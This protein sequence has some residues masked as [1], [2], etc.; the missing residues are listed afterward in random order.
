[1]YAGV[2][3]HVWRSHVT[4]MQESVT[5]MQD[6]RHTYGRVISQDEGVM[7]HM[8]RSHVTH[9]EESCDTCGGVM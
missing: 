2:M 5:C 4:C 7:S 1:M 3:S 8:W 9:V 6:L